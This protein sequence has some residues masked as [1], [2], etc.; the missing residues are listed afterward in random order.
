MIT[1]LIAVGVNLGIFLVLAIWLLISERFLVRYGDCEISVNDGSLILEKKGGV[2]LLTALYDNK[3]FIPS[4][5]GGKATCGYCK[6]NVVSGGGPVLPTELPFLNR[7]E[8][9]SG[10][11]L[12]CQVKLK[13][14]IQISIPEELLSV[15]EYRARVSRLVTLTHDIKEIN[16]ELLDSEELEHRPGMYIQ[17]QAPSPDGPV[18]RAYSIST[19]VYTK[20]EVQIIVRLIPDGIASTYLHNLK[21]GDEVMFTGPYGEFKLSENPDT[22]VMCIGGGSGMAPIKS[23][24]ESIYYEWPDRTCYLFFGCRSTS[25]VFYLDKFREMQKKFPNLKVHYALSDPKEGEQWDGDSG[26]IHLS[27][28]KRLPDSLDLQTFLCGPPPM[29]EAV[30]GVIKDKGYNPDEAFYDKF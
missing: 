9:K 27:V 1:G 17:V 18:F 12:A 7:S 20:N 10:T 15:K 26:F 25:D 19:P 14:N 29:I 6:V 3:V 11:R 5:C 30:K 28:D 13:E 8:V 16:F 22:A 2:S 23:I 24:I 4:A 21:E